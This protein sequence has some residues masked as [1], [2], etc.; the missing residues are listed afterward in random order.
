MCVYLDEIEGLFSSVNLESKTKPGK[1][2]KGQ[3]K[4]GRGEEHGWDEEEKDVLLEHEGRTPTKRHDA[5]H[6]R[7]SDFP[8]GD[9][10]VKKL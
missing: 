8:R 7:R 1:R 9:C 2:I 6:Q 5:A 3:S 10:N 4:P